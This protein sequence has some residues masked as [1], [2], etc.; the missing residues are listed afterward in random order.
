MNIRFAIVLFILLNDLVTG[1]TVSNSHNQCFRFFSPLNEDKYRSDVPSDSLGLPL[2]NLLYL[3][4][5]DGSLIAPFIQFP[6]LSTSFNVWGLEVDADDRSSFEDLVAAIVSFVL[7]FPTGIY[8]VGESNGGLL[9]AEVALQLENSS[10]DS[11]HG[12]CLINPA[13]SYLRSTFGIKAPAV[14]NL[15]HPLYS[16]GL[17]SLLPLFLDKHQF[18]QLLKIVNGAYLPSVIDSPAREAYMGR[19]AMTLGQRLPV[20]PQATLV[21]RLDKWLATGCL[22]VTDERLAVLRTRCLVVCGDADLVLPSLDE[23]ERLS[24]VIPGCETFVVQGAGHCSTC[25]SRC[26]L[27]AVLRNRFEELQRPGLRTAMK[28]EAF[29]GIGTWEFGMETRKHPAVGPLNYWKL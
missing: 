19:I 2:P 4:G 29:E 23:A 27:A 26:D 1:L 22:A 3:P 6:E 16:A 25:G 8:L 18:P 5:F 28:P 9:A 11:L 14:A 15:P 13:T 17:A 12:L 24:K 21:W 20:M 7:E 10:Q